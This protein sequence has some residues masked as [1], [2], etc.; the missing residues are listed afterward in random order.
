MI[1]CDRPGVVEIKNKMDE[2]VR[3]YYS[4]STDYAS[5]ISREVEINPGDKEKIYLG[6]GT[7]WTESL[8][9]YHTENLIDTVFL[10]VGTTAYYCPTISCKQAMF[11]ME[12]RKSGR[13]ILI[14]IDSYLIEGYFQQKNP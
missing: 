11:N 13:R 5:S 14:E 7:K 2:E 8:L 12:R 1:S 6:F 4:M 3:F 10:E 9:K